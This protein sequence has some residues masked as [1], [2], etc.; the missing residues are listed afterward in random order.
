MAM[1]E[2]TYMN[3][4]RRNRTERCRMVVQVGSPGIPM[5]YCAEP[6]QK[7]AKGKYDDIVCGRH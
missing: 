7:N 3:D 5:L 2:T 4:W 1:D 6:L